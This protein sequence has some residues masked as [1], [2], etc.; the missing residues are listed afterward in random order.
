MRGGAFVLR[1]R[2]ILGFLVLVA[3]LVAA[4]LFL[5]RNW[6]LVGGGDGL[7]GATLVAG[8]AVVP[9]GTAGAAGATG[10]PRPAAA[11]ASATASTAAGTGYF[12]AAR[13]RRAQAESRELAGLQQLAADSS[14]SATVRA[15]A[16]QQILQLEQQQ[17]E[18]VTAELVLQAKGYPQSLVMLAPAGATVVVGTSRFTAADAALVGQAVA[19]VA[20]MDPAQVQIVPHAVS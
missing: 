12:A 9:A 15:E 11:A 7:S 17:Q 19:Q 10:T 5:A 2:A 1:R 13:L 20:G 3:L 18:E 6:S 8:R 4:S 14:A 16:Q